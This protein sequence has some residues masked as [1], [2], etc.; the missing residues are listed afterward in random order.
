[1]NTGAREVFL[2]GGS[3]NV[4]SGPNVARD[5]LPAGHSGQTETFGPAAP[6]SASRSTC[7]RP[8]SSRGRSE[9]FFSFFFRGRA[10]TWQ[11]GCNSFG[12]SLGARMFQQIFWRLD[13]D[14]PELP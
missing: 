6:L 10:G 2:L 5:S 4:T 13:L 11:Q 12:H 9:G 3:L 14:D 1:M 8:G 7:F